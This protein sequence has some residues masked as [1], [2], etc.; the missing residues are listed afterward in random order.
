MFLV[1]ST[2]RKLLILASILGVMFSLSAVESMLAQTKP[3][4]RAAARPAARASKVGVVN[5][6]EAIAGTETGKKEIDAMQQRFNPKQAALKTRGDEVEKLKTEL[7]AAS[8]KLSEDERGKRTDEI[9]K[10]QK[11]LQADFEEFQSEVQKAEQ[12][13]MGR[14]GPKMMDVLDKYAKAHGYT[15]IL[16]VSSQQTPVL[17]AAEG[18]NLTKELIS[19]YDAVAASAKP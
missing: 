16:D 10:K 3:A 6:Q 9:M 18:T 4:A 13:V 19:A 1:R 5:V 17:W 7:L 2:N 8:D 14:I 12:D 15:V 11:S